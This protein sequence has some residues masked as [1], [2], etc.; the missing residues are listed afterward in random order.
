MITPATAGRFDAGIRRILIMI[1]SI[2]CSFIW[3]SRS[4]LAK[5]LYV[6]CSFN[7][8]VHFFNRLIKLLPCLFG[9]PLLTTGQ[10][11]N[12]N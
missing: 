12:E 2:P 3:L 9:W 1:F 6:Q 4:V 5:P 8:F 11:E 10:A 7:L